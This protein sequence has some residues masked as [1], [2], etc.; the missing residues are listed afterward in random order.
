MWNNWS[1]AIQ[2]VEMGKG[3]S[4]LGNSL[5]APSALCTELLHEPEI[6]SIGIFLE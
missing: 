6:P 2:L 4:A 3:S 5:N 1:P